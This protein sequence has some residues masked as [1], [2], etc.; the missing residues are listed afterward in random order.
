MAMAIIAGVNAANASLTL[1][2]N[3][4]PFDEAS[5]LARSWD[6]KLR[7]LNISHLSE[8]ASKSLELKHSRIVLISESKYLRKGHPKNRALK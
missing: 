6:F 8:Q 5:N 3:V 7:S 1:L 2:S 4:G